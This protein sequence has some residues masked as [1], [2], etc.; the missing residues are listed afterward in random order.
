MINGYL[1][2]N[3]MAEKWGVSTRRVQIMCAK[4]E[5]KGA[6]KFGRSWAIPEDTNRPSDGRITTGEYKNWRKKPEDL[7]KGDR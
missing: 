6:V 1:T 7:M 2:A 4:E 3:E 5:I